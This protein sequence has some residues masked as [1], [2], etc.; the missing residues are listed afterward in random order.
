[1]DINF[2]KAL[3][4][5]IKSG[6]RI[7]LPQN[8]FFTPEGE[9]VCLER[10]GG[11][12]RYPYTGSGILLWAKSNG[13]ISACEGNFNVFREANYNE[14]AVV[15]FFGGIKTEDR[16]RPVSITG[17]DRI[18]GETG[19]ERYVVYTDEFGYYIAEAGE[20]V[21]ALRLGTDK[22][23]HMRFTLGGY[24]LSGEDKEIYLASYFEP[25][26]RYIEAEGF[27][28]RMTKYG[29]FSEGKYAFSSFNACFDSL[30]IH[31][32]KPERFSE[33]SHTVS[34]SEFLGASDRNLA[35]ADSL[36]NGKFEKNVYSVN[37][38]HLP[39]ASDIFR[40]C[41]PPSGEAVVDYELT[42]VH[43]KTADEVLK[44]DEEN[45]AAL[46]GDFEME[47]D[48]KIFDNFDMSFEAPEYGDL[49]PAK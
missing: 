10:K 8:C 7:P 22:N 16:Y 21:F 20:A 6:K 37:T 28:N 2:I 1:M 19:V 14:D 43:G 49:D 46:I 13:Y 4:E 36:V 11:T 25:M 40:I 32:R 39:A 23:G 35:N 30:L 3:L 34:R 18:S 38:T 42:V 5:K 26:L 27:F 48:R 9:I 45:A 47:T 41:L 12:S 44:D 24:N 15:N 29:R 17:A 31:C 33:E